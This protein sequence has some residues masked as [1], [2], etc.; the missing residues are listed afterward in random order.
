MSNKINKN[1]TQKISKQIQK[2]TNA[3]L[4][5]NIINEKNNIHLNTYIYLEYF[6]ANEADV[7]IDVVAG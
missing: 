6:D 7:Q 3:Y 5:N 4:E 1:N 2:Q